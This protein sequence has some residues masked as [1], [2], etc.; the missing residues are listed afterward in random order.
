[1]RSA[2]LSLAGA[3]DSVCGRRIVPTPIRSFTARISRKIILLYKKRLPTPL[4]DI[5]PP[6]TFLT[7]SRQGHWPRRKARRWNDRLNQ[8]QERNCCEWPRTEHMGRPFKATLDSLEQLF[9]HFA[10]NIREPE[11]APLKT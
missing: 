10:G 8:R 6:S 1:M 11:I 2:K 3:A 7:Y 5:G 9:H 4:L